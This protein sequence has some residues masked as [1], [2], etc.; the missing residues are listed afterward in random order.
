MYKCGISIPDLW[1]IRNAFI[2]MQINPPP[3]FSFNN[4]HREVYPLI[5]ALFKER[6]HAVGYGNI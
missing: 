2:F 6:T 5:F 4:N 3:F 1:R